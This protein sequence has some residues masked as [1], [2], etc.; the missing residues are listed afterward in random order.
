MVAGLVAAMPT[1][2]ILVAVGLVPL[3]KLTAVHRSRPGRQCTLQLPAGR[4]QTVLAHPML[5]VMVP[6]RRPGM[7]RHAHLILMR[8]EE[9]RQPGMLVLGRLILMRQDPMG[10]P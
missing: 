1:L 7:L 10:V 3:S 5:T 2:I 6:E 4:Q 8:M 9:G